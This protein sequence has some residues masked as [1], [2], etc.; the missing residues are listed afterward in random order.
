MRTQ[1]KLEQDLA[2]KILDIMNDKIRQYGI[3]EDRY[4]CENPSDFKWSEVIL[5]QKKSLESVKNNFRTIVNIHFQRYSLVLDLEKLVA[6]SLFIPSGIPLFESDD[7]DVFSSQFLEKF[8]AMKLIDVEKMAKINGIFLIIIATC[9]LLN[10]GG[11]PYTYLLL[12]VALSCFLYLQRETISAK[13]L[14][15]N[16]LDALVNAFITK[17]QYGNKQKSAMLKSFRELEDMVDKL[18]PN[19]VKIKAHLLKDI[20][21]IQREMSVDLCSLLA[22]EEKE[23]KEISAKFRSLSLDQGVEAKEPGYDRLTGMLKRFFFRLD[24]VEERRKRLKEFISHLEKHKIKPDPI[25][26]VVSD[27]L[28]IMG[29]RLAGEDKYLIDKLKQDMTTLLKP[30]R[31]S[32]NMSLQDADDI[33][34]ISGSTSSSSS[35]SSSGSSS[36]SSSSNFSSR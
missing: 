24:L 34:L 23:H 19:S 33:A 14:N 25:P 11:F 1:R 9:L 28:G 13:N 27:I 12:F 5:D 26:T 30:P 31:L 4:P 35:S 32:R 21:Q 36:S 18:M 17:N 8:H 6:R 10:S 20:K 22:G 16:P 2:K 15:S 29:R 7:S 3:Q